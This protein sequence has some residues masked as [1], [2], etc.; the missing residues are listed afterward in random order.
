MG[1][2]L[3]L[4][5]TVLIIISIIISSGQAATAKGNPHVIIEVR[6]GKTSHLH[7]NHAINNVTLWCQAEER[8]TPLSIR[9][10]GFVRK[11]DGVLL[12][13]KL[14]NNRT[15]A[16][17]SFG[18]ASVEV[19]GNYTCKI[20]TTDGRTIT[21]NHQVFVRPLAYSSG[22]V[23]FD[24]R[25]NDSFYFDA[26]GLTVVRG[27]DASLECPIF[28]FPA[29]SFEWRKGEDLRPIISDERIKLKNDGSLHISTVTDEDRDIYECTASNSFTV[30]GKPETFRLRISRKLR[31]K[32]EYAWLWPLLIIIVMIFIL[33]VI[34]SITECRKKKENDQKPTNS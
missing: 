34:I 6:I 29:V 7:P 16:I 25:R 12:N 5:N 8:N 21:G 2:A 26:T 30:D 3:V 20:H 1:L 33:A 28:A 27:T 14:T 24:A 15:R 13:A 4:G 10:A 32:G 22:N 17:H 23:R 18:K 9:S 31:V 19:A 11:K